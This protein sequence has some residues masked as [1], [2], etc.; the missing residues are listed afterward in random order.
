MA[1]GIGASGIAGL[2]L[3]VLPPPTQSALATATTGGTILAGTYRYVVT[4]INA[5]GETKASNEQT[6]VTTGSTS[7]VTVTWVAVPGATGYKLYK[8]AAGGAS[9]TELLY[10]TVGAVTSDIDTSPGSPSGA[11]PTT[12]TAS[13][14]N[15]YLAPTKFFPFMSESLVFQQDTIW[16]RPI[17]QSA[18]VI[19]AV[20]GN[21]HTEGD[22]GMEGLE[23]VVVY[24]LKASRTTLVKTGS[25]PNF[26]YTF[27]PNA[28]GVAINTLSLT[29]VR[30]GV[31]FGYTGICLSS[32][33]FTVE[34][35][36]LMFNVSLM[37]SDEA[38]QSLPVPTWPTTTPF[39][40]GQY[41][42]EIPTGTPV[43]DSDAFEFTVEH[44]AEPQYRLKTPGRGAQFIKYGENNSTLTLERDFDNRTDYDNFKA[45]TS[46]SITLTATKTANNSIS[47]LMPVAIKDTYEVTAPGQGDLVRSSVAYQSVIDGTG[48]AWQIVVK[49][50]EDI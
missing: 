13:N 26:T 27:T 2:A 16:R 32:M 47:M 21:V 3:E 8:T 1:P 35:G 49:T 50:Q 9:G 19:G 29:L 7:T 22:M 45:L 44:N 37:G 14:P 33:T 24:F 12:N 15:T 10:K 41:S 4:A 40:A 28:A 6:I 11:F 5:N 34:D 38:V 31:V 42:M 48:K 25:A 20:P 30:N 17:R 43:V 36:I 39:G 18:D 23:D 46:Q